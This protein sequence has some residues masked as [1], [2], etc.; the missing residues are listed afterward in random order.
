LPTWKP[1]VKMQIFRKPWILALLFLFLDQDRYCSAA[2]KYFF[3]FYFGQ[4]TT[5]ELLSPLSQNIQLLDS[6]VMVGAWGWAIRNFWNGAFSVELEGQLG[7][8]FGGQENW[9]INLAIAGRWHKFPWQKK[10]DTSIAWG[11]GPS[12]ATEVP[13][14]EVKINGE[15]RRWLIYWFAEAALGTSKNDW[16]WVFRIHHRSPG[17]GLFGTEGGANIL[18]SGLKFYF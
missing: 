11:I 6:Y 3:T 14:V 7:K 1:L 18:S 4:I 16:K 17:F 2:H 12:Y 5:G 9:E 13:P 10:M 15:S 8:Y